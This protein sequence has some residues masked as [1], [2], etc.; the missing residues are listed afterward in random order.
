MPGDWQQEK[1][2]QQQRPKSQKARGALAS[3]RGSKRKGSSQRVFRAAA[4][5]GQ[6]TAPKTPLPRPQL[7]MPNTPEKQLQLL[8]HELEDWADTL[9]KPDQQL[10][11]QGQAEEIQY[12]ETEQ[13]LQQPQQ[14][15][16]EDEFYIG[17]RSFGRA[18]NPSGYPH[19]KSKAGQGL[20]NTLCALQEV[21][22]EKYC[23][24]VSILVSDKD[25]DF[26]TGRY[27]GLLDTTQFKG[28]LCV[29]PMGPHGAF[30]NWDARHHY[31]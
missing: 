4:R 25:P 24:R 26:T 17:V 16:A 14:P 7:R 10:L 9:E 12:H 5:P 20:R 2:Q 22:P 19:R 18:G 23:C 15:E 28:Q 3:F 29:C 31:G 27:K 13:K 11:E 8:E 6:A 30:R 1:E 21:L